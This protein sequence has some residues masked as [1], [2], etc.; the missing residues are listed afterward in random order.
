MNKLLIPIFTFVC[1]AQA[2]DFNI[3]VQK[4]MDDLHT[5]AKSENPKFHKFD[6]NR[7]KQI[8]TSEH[9]GKKGKLIS[10]VSCH[11]NDLKQ[12]GENVS[13]TKLIE[14][15]SP[16]VNA[17]RFSK[18]KTIKKWL[19]RNFRD[20]YNREGTAQEKGDVITYIVNQK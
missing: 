4:Y 18:V 3:Q 12:N 9:I 2:N 7:G 6:Y 13:T 5:K 17:K 20:V 15:L 1:V 8:F 14:P 16:S 11:T 19:R 10:C